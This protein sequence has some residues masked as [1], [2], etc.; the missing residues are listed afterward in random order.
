[1]GT[2]SLIL[3]LVLHPEVQKKAQDELRSVLGDLLPTFEDKL[4]L[5][6]VAAV[7]KEVH[8]WRPPLPLVLPH[9]VT[10]DGIYGKY[11][12]PTEAIVTGNAW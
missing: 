4:P 6:Y 8:R 9:A 2:L 5:L 12:I 10:Q 7:G 1:M 3:I 11:F